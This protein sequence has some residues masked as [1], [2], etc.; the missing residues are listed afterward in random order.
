[1]NKTNSTEQA[2]NHQ[3]SAQVTAIMDLVTQARATVQELE[4]M[5]NKLC[6]LPSPD[7]GPIKNGAIYTLRY[8]WSQLALFEEKAQ[9]ASATESTGQFYLLKAAQLR[10][11]I[12]DPANSERFADEG[13]M[14]Q[15]ERAA[16]EQAS[17]VA[18]QLTNARSYYLYGIHA[19]AVTVRGLLALVVKEK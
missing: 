19:P 3:P 11:R 4:S 14:R 16:D 7:T 17:A 15:Y 5:V 13:Y 10:A 8:M 12:D 9:H 6:G 2:I 18:G 1:M